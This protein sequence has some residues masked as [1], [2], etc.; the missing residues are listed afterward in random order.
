[1]EEKIRILVKKFRFKSF[2]T[3]KKSFPLEENIQLLRVPAKIMFV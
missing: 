3:E 1:M 2:F